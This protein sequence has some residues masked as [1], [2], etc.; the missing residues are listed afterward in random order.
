MLLL[1]WF[2]ASAEAACVERVT[3]DTL[4]TRVQ[5]LVEPVAFAEDSVAAELDAIEAALRAGCLEMTI[6]RETLGALFMAQGAY[7]LL[8]GGDP[9]RADAYLRRAAALTA[10]IEPAYG[11][12]VEEA[13]RAAINGMRGDAILELSFPT[14]PEVVV[15]D[16]EVLY[17]AVERRVLLG[18]HLVQ[19][20]SA[21]LGWSAEWVELNVWGERRLVGGGPPLPDELGPL[22][23]EPDKTPRA[24]TPRAKTPRDPSARPRRS[25]HRPRGL[26]PER[27]AGDHHGGS[28]RR[29]PRVY[30]DPQRRG[31]PG[32]AL[33]VWAAQPR[34]L[35]DADADRLALGGPALPNE[36]RALYGLRRDKPLSL[37]VGLLLLNQPTVAFERV[38]LTAEGAQV[39]VEAPSFGAAPGA[40]PLLSVG[41]GGGETS[42]WSASA[43][44]AWTSSPEAGAAA[45][46]ALA[47][48]VA[49]PVGPVRLILGAELGALKA[50]ESQPGPWLYPQVV[51]GVQWSR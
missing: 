32:R 11:L 39:A 42:L 48:Q 6:P 23:E 15:V 35:S 50:M 28:S 13:Y 22:P 51:G 8:R 41:L 25:R 31:P 24:K 16:G 34:R 9:I 43:R 30:A 33:C 2:V 36:L 27:G 1:S 37:G 20:Y 40:G 19:W 5:A 38:L 10:P 17:D 26:R 18:A 49:L 3:A 7:E 14:R 45:S 46:G 44:V 21:D 4:T 29:R 12:K 47:A